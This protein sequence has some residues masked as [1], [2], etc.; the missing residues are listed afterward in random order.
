MARSVT[1]AVLDEGLACAVL[2]PRDGLVLEGP[3]PEGPVLEGAPPPPGG[4]TL[5]GLVLGQAAS[6]ERELLQLEG[7]FAS[8]RRTVRLSSAGP[9]RCLVVQTVELELGLPWWSWL[10]ALPLRIALGGITPTGSGRMPWW[11]A[12]QRLG[13][14][15]ALVIASLAALVAVQGVVAGALPETL[16]Y[17][18]S[19]MHA[20]TLGQAVVFAAVGLSA[21]PA[22]LALVLADKRG[23]HGVVVWGTA[24]AVAFSGLSALAPSVTWLLASQFLVGALVGAAGIAAVVVA[25]EEVPAGCRAWSLGVLGMAGG[26]GAGVPLALLPVAGLGPGGWRWVYALSAAALPV[27]VLSARQ[28]PESMRWRASQGQGSIGDRPGQASRGRP[29][30][31]SAPMG[32]HLS[33]RHEPRRPASKGSRLSLPAP[34]R[35]ALVAAGALLLALFATPAEQFQTEFLRRQRGYSP[36]SISVLQQLAGTLGGLGGLLGGRLADTHGRRPVGAASVALAMA[37]TLVSYFFR[38]WLM[39][40]GAA[41]GELCL[42]ATVPVLGV[43]GAE[44]FATRSRARAAGSVGAATALGGATGLLVAGALAGPKGAGLAPTLGVLALGPVLLVVL[45][46]SCYPETARASL[47]QLAPGQAVAPGPTATA[48]LSRPPPPPAV[49][50][51]GQ[52]PPTRPS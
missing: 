46:F 38:G 21:L 40:S 25:V 5:A 33:R 17:A 44:L 9:G 16:T 49:A 7:P 48:R 37:A 51:R 42:Y 12:P 31:T 4:T 28:L 15:A 45:L 20:S 24:S 47:E 43:Y 30:S 14:R 50:S 27:V 29:P 1:Q 19:E 10:L 13:R 2:E 6:V 36:V 18:A 32:P 3:V 41:I 35:L 52:R 11:A 22:L 39:W 34:S 26:L 8:Y 23:R